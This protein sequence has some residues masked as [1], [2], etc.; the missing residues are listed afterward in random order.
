V[1]IHES[2]NCR[3]IYYYTLL[4]KLNFTSGNSFCWPGCSNVSV[5]LPEGGPGHHSRYSDSLQAGQSADQILVGKCPDWPW[6]PPSSFLGVKWPVHGVYHPPP[7][8]TGV[9]EK[10]E[11]YLYPPPSGPSWS[12]LGWPLPYSL[13]MALWGLKHV[14]V[15]EC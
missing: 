3:M 1:R 7:S 9:Q 15:T 5:I 8:S 12:V 4:T 14:G 6:G 11:L 10:V 2:R 13:K